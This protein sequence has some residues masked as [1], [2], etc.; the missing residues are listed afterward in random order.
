MSP[1]ILSHCLDTLLTRPRYAETEV[2][3]YMRDAINE[4][5][6]A[7]KRLFLSHFTSSTHHPWDTPED[8]PREKYFG[9]QHKDMDAF[10]NANRF[11]DA[12]LAD[13]M[14]LLHEA[15]IANETLTVFVGDQYVTQS[16]TF[17][18][19]YIDIFQ[20]P[21]VRRGLPDDRN[22]R[23]PTHQQLPRPPPLPPP[24]P[25]PHANLL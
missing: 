12:W 9:E 20:W 6:A 5:L 2:K 11:V 1:H 24:P 13:L 14:G 21:S 19:I 18:H 22:L 3:P 25:S 7:N 15:G 10:L 17:C 16:L 4:T 23:Q 8:F